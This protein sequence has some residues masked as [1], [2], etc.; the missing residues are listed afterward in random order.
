MFRN[1]AHFRKLLHH[2][3]NFY[4]VVNELGNSSVAI[5]RYAMNVTDERYYFIEMQ[6]YWLGKVNSANIVKHFNISRTQAQKYLSSYQK[7][8]PNNLSYESSLK[9]FVLTS[10]FSAGFIQCDANEYLD[11]LDGAHSKTFP[12]LIDANNV[13]NSS[14]SIPKRKVSPSVIRQIVHAIEHR[15]RI[16]VD[17]V[18]LSNPDREGR[19]IQPHVFVK[20]GLR[21]HL[22]AY[23][24]K[25]QAFRDFVLSRFAGDTSL[26]GNA[27]HFSHDDE[28]WNTY[29]DITLAPDRRLNQAQ[30]AVI[31][32]EYMMNNGKLVI[33]TRGAL[34]QYLLQEMQVSIKTHDAHPEA[35]QLVLVNQKDIQ[36]WL[37]HT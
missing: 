34:A 5:W 31:E 11:W 33:R 10:A 1:K 15:S 8:F 18:S 32:N 22:R 16:E 19:V 3:L 27:T 7:R 24:E 28:A 23:D 30:Q 9:G 36:Q 20:T 14:L 4:S 17:Y 21:W 6:C 26:L 2:A 29:V 13:T 12:N 25:H 35:Q 37:F